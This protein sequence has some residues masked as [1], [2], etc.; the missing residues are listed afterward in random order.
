M[1]NLNCAINLLK[2]F[3]IKEQFD[4]EIGKKRYE[5]NINIFNISNKVS[6]VTKYD[7][8]SSVQYYL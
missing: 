8:L 5:L 7:H 1:I 4:L 2:I 3:H 6:T